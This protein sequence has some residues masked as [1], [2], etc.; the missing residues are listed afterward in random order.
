MASEEISEGWREECAKPSTGRMTQNL[1][2]PLH[3][4]LGL[5]KNFV[6]AMDRTGSAFKYLAEKFLDSAKRKLKRGFFMGPQICMIFRDV[7]F[8]SFL[9]V[10]EKK[11]W[12]TFRLVS[13]N[14]LG[15]IRAENYKEL[16]EDILSLYHKLDCDMSLKIHM[17]HSH[18]DFFRHN[19]GMFSD[20][21]GEGFVRKLQRWRKD[22]KES[23]P[24]E[25]WLTIVWT[26]VRNAP[27]HLHER[28]SKRS[29]K[30]K[31]TFIVTCPMYIF[32]K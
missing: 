13:T 11:A 24:L 18:L 6:K 3:F 8:D 25:C 28:H 30:Q 1:L 19:Y 21:H 15:N 2:P 29:C 4:V 10:D 5:M 9:Q 22:I 32:L 17:L 16:I 20:E 31:W 26:L 27:G 23:V 12:D 14:F 7:M